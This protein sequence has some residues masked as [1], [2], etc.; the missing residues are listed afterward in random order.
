MIAVLGLEPLAAARKFLAT[1]AAPT[2]A[3]ARMEVVQ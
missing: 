1:P 2:V 3:P